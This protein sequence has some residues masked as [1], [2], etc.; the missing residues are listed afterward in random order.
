MQA[1]EYDF[2]VGQPVATAAEQSQAATRPALVVADVARSGVADSNADLQYRLAY[3]SA[4]QLRAYQQARWSQ[5]PASLVQQT[6][7][8]ELARHQPVLSGDGARAAARGLMPGV[9]LL[10]LELAEFSHV[11]TTPTQS[12]GVLRLRA[13]LVEPRVQGEVLRGQRLF[14]TQVPA[15]SANAEGGAAAL[16]EAARLAASDLAAWLD[17]APR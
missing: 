6:V 7:L 1:V 2:G 10:R 16:G 8:A 13:T 3:D 12:A 17:Q 9:L 11:F 5:P 4:Q 15:V 14:S